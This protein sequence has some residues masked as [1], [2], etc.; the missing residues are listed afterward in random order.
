MS[1]ELVGA[2]AL[3]IPILA[4]M[5]PMVA[6]LSRQH[7]IGR[8]AS[9]RAEA[10]KMYERLALEKLDVIKTA[11]AM[12]YKQDELGELYQRLEQLI[13]TEQLQALLS[14]EAPAVP[15]APAGLQQ[16][17]LTAELDEVRRLRAH[18]QK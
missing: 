8:K 4:L 9:E 14:D 11:V 5:I 1:G 10:R 13:G 16:A 7:V 15:T 6:I 18:R 17:E 3:M 2:L 12:G